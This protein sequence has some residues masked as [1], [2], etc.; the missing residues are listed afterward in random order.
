MTH[1]KYEI[2]KRH[3]VAIY[4]NTSFAGILRAK[5]RGCVE[6]QASD[7]HDQR[8]DKCALVANEVEHSSCA[9]T[10]EQIAKEEGEGYEGGQ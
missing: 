5:S 10:V 8:A 3:E 9:R 6:Q 4:Y 7:H 2:A 1:E